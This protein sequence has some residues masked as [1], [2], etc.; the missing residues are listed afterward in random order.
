MGVGGTMAPRSDS[1]A[2]TPPPPRTA[3]LALLLLL[4]LK[5]AFVHG[6]N[7]RTFS[8]FHFTSEPRDTVAA[9]GSSIVLN[10]SVRTSEGTPRIEWKKDG[11][12]INL[13]TDERRA[14]LPGGSLQLQNVLHG[15]HHKPDEGTYQC[16]ATVDSLGTI[17]SRTARL[18]VAGVPRV[19]VQ[20][21]PMSAHVGDAAV[22]SCEVGGEPMPGV[23]W[24]KD[25]ANLTLDGRRLAL[26]AGGALLVEHVEA[27]DA[28]VYRCV[29]ENIAS[30]RASDEAELEV[31]AESSVPRKPVFLRHASDVTVRAGL[32]ATLDCAVSGHPRPSL[33]WLKE[34]HPVRES[35]GRV[36]MLPNGQLRFSEAAVEDSGIYQCVVTGE[37]ETLKA[38]AELSVQT[39]PVF[40]KRPRDT[41]AYEGM[42]VVL[43]CS[44][45]GHP[46]PTVKWVKNGDIVIP[47]DYFQIVDDHNLKILGLVRSDEGI[48]QCIAESEAGNAQ[49]SAQLLVLE[50]D[51]IGHSVSPNPSSHPPS[52]TG[53]AANDR[54]RTAS[55]GEAPL[56]SAPRDVV[57]ALV[58]TRFVKLMWRAPADPQGDILGYTVFYAKEKAN[59]ERAVN[60]TK[61]GDL[62]VTVVDLHPEAEYSFRVMAL[63]R[64]GLGESSQTIRVATQAEVQVPGPAM[65]LEAE[66]TSATSITL[67]WDMPISG[68]GPILNYRLYYMERSP[69]VDGEQEVDVGGQSYSMHGLKKHTEYGFRVVA[70][71]R[72]G[73][74]ASTEDVVARTYSDVPSAP[75]SNVTIEVLNSK[76]IIVRWLP[77]PQGTQNGPITGYKI[78]HKKGFRRGETENTEGNQLW[79]QLS[80]LEK[81][82]EYSFRVAAMNINGTGPSSEWVSAETFEDD[83]DESRVPDQPSSLHVRPLTTSIV[84]SWTPPASHGVMVRGYLIGYGVGSPY[85]ETIRVDTKQRY[86]AIDNL[87]PNHQYVISLRA[88]NQM[89]QGVPLYESATTRAVTVPDLPTPM[90]PP[91]GVQAFVISHDTI[92]VTW[93]DNTLAKNQRI[94]DARHYTI[95]WKTY[96]STTAKYKTANS[97]TFTYLVS[98]LKPST[99]YEFS[100]M[101]TKGRRSSTWSM[102]A[103]GTTMEAVPSSAPK[104]LT[105]ISKEG[106]P[107]TVIVNWQPP[108][109][110]NGK[111]TGYIIYYTTDATAELHDWVVEP[112]VGDRLSHQ[113]QELTLDTGYYFKIQARNAKGM[114]PLSDAVSF[115]TPKVSTTAAKGAVGEGG[116]WPGNPFDRASFNDA[117]TGQI[118]P[119]Q[120]ARGSALDNN[121]LIIIVVTVGGVTVIAVIVLAVV[122]TRRSAATQ[123]KKRSAHKPNNGSGKRKGNPKDLKPPD[124]WIHHETVALK[125]MDKSPGPDSALAD[126]PMTHGS[127]E[128]EGYGRES[129]DGMSTMERS[130]AARHA[131]RPKIVIPGESQSQL[132]ATASRHHNPAKNHPSYLSLPRPPPPHHHH[133]HHHHHHQLSPL[134]PAPSPPPL[135]GTPSPSCSFPGPPAYDVCIVG[136]PGAGG[137]RASAR[138][139]LQQSPS[140]EMAPGPV[141]GLGESDGCPTAGPAA[142]AGPAVASVVA[143]DDPPGRHLPTAHVRPSQPLTSFA[144]PVVPAHPSVDGAAA[145]GSVGPLHPQGGPQLLPARTASVGTLGRT[146]APLPVTMPSAPDAPVEPS[147]HPFEDTESTFGQD[148]EELSAEMAN[149]EGLMK[150]LNAIT[151]SGI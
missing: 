29:A 53:A 85:A 145:V 151:S 147:H 45:T 47:S 38:H 126:T 95:R 59:R 7:K 104:D 69:G 125:P 141:P 146:R 37:N 54:H 8:P 91:V 2:G 1:P 20:P 74:G 112:V 123:K 12:F 72:H 120:G 124:L 113:V 6:L 3:L 76:T 33:R 31:L 98:S 4:L 106:K 77:P 139:S 111:I 36:T 28:G 46:V 68:N 49:S 102:T 70:V 149:L 62:Q 17:V 80:G 48:Y 121:L 57:A 44:V 60:T 88:F 41:L 83:L 35:S 90:L 140:G 78:R 108:V 129:E 109:E 135:T 86:Y 23:R 16:V 67:S 81:G 115:R 40:A 73:P 14:L 34:G 50:R 64:H 150:D 89:G 82:S 114:G 63:S 56:P 11:T 92:R 58:S 133:H 110:A 128:I 39:A 148:D 142:A 101:V 144:V 119:P 27:G 22:L 65:N 43:A 18:V 122:C 87:E 132:L 93:A 32:S 127:H 55:G 61:P 117:P 107:R 79:H 19:T 138:D 51:D 25:R 96:F 75:P 71:N 42:D 24:Q 118:P 52:V 94:P 103:Q 15:K 116:S 134:P 136:L 10:C 137:G 5:V 9:R 30:S 100:V 143:D 66:V 84:V 131:M 105:V 99:L 21:E 13:A 130:I 26:L 97:T